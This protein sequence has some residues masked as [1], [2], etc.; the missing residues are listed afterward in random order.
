MKHEKQQLV[1][2]VAKSGTSYFFL[3]WHC[4]FTFTPNVTITFWQLCK[5][6]TFLALK[7]FFSS[8]SVVITIFENQVL[9]ASSISNNWPNI[10]GL[11]SCTPVMKA[12]FLRTVQLRKIKTGEANENVSFVSSCSGTPEFCSSFGAT[13]RQ[14]FTQ[15]SKKSCML[16]N[17]ID[18]HKPFSFEPLASVIFLLLSSFHLASVCVRPQW[19]A[20]HFAFRSAYWSAWIWAPLLCRLFILLL[21]P[22]SRNR[23]TRFFPHVVCF[24][25]LFPEM[26]VEA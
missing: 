2:F 5:N 9:A 13:S 20:G 18:P 4:I 15:E 22:S 3:R 21:S 8:N 26:T 25:P 12:F 14:K 11:R 19:Y 10:T 1:L 6:Q 16:N 24:P 23:C 7:K 17:V